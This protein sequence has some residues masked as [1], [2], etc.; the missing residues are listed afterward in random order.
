MTD[1][2]FYE[3]PTFATI[4][5][6]KTGRIEQ[7]DH[8]QLTWNNFLLLTK[9]QEYKTFILLNNGYRLLINRSIKQVL[10][11]FSHTNHCY[12]RCNIPY[13]E[14]LGERNPIKSY[15]AGRNRL[16]PSM[17]TNNAEVVYYMAKPMKMHYY[18][19]LQ[20]GMMLMFETSKFAIN[21]L[22]PAYA[23]KFQKI[24]AQADEISHMHLL[25]LREKLLRYGM[26]EECN[27]LVNE[28]FLHSELTKKAYEIKRHVY[29]YVLN[30]LYE[31]LYGERMGDQ[32][33]R[34]LLD[35]LFDTWKR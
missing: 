34:R 28:Y 35:I 29:S 31:S 23:N 24:L 11:D 25:E 5:Q 8:Y 20:Q 14:M 32:E 30:T 16:V 9:Y 17:G 27:C 1:S 2:P 3:T 4:E 13:Y 6:L 7:V 10:R 15:V 22:V 18:S 19:E 33:M 21:V 12:A 26:E